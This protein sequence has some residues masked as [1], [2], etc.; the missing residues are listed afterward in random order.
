MPSISGPN[1]EENGSRL[2]DAIRDRAPVLGSAASQASSRRYAMLNG[3]AK[4]TPVRLRRQ[5]VTVQDVLR[6][7]GRPIDQFDPRSGCDRVVTQGCMC[8]DTALAD[9]GQFAV[10]AEPLPVLS[11][12]PDKG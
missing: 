12:T 2:E 5:A 11:M 7:T 9:A 8:N 3:E 1:G 6:W 10:Q 4:S